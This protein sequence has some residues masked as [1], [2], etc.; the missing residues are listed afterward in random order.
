M[1]VPE[2]GKYA[3]IY[4]MNADSGRP[5]YIYPVTEIQGELLKNYTGNAKEKILFEDALN[6]SSNIK[7]KQTT[8]E[9]VVNDGIDYAVKYNELKTAFDQLKTDHDAIINLLQTWVVAPNDGGAALQ[10]AATALA[11]STADMTNSKVE[12]V[13]L[14]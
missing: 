7:Y 3:E 12:K 4:F 13:R 2:I 9:Y 14:P 8:Q 10:A 11:P 1:I 6:K 5:V